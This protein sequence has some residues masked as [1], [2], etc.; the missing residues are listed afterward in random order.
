M[1]SE[2]FK[3]ALTNGIFAALFVALLWYVLKDSADREKKYQKTIDKLSSHL[4]IVE[5][6][7]EDVIEVKSLVQ[8]KRKN[9]KSTQTG[10]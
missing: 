9:K 7:K 1:W 6:I 4:D 8:S 2:I 10:E 3:V 5:D